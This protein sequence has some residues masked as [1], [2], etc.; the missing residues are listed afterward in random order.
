MNAH[1]KITYLFTHTI[2]YPV[3]SDGNIIFSEVRA[4]VKK[5]ST[6]INMYKSIT[7]SLNKTI[8]LSGNHLIYARKNSSEKLHPM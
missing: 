6:V 8:R 1:Q 7:T 5:Q 3:T 4:F 2:F